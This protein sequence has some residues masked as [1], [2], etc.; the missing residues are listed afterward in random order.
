[1]ILNNVLYDEAMHHIRNPKYNK[2]KENVKFTTPTQQSHNN[3]SH[4][5]GPHTLGPTLMCGVVVWLL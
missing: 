4:E 2:Q 3:P 1:M 5:G